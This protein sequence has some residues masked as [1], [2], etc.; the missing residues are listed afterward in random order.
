MKT[1]KTIDDLIEREKQQLA[2]IARMRELQQSLL[3][4]KEGAG[5]SDARFIEI[6]LCYIFN[7]YDIESV[8]KFHDYAID[9]MGCFS[10]G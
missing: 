4:M 5:V 2:R 8:E 7:G 1:T 3:Q 9:Q 6:V 10:E